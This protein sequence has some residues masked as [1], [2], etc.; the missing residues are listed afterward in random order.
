MNQ[1]GSTRSAWFTGV[2]DHNY[3]FRIRAR[4]VAGNQ[5]DYAATTSTHINACTPNDFEPDDDKDHARAIQVEAAAEIHKI[6]GAGDVDWFAFAPNP[7]TSYI[8]YTNQLG[9]TTDTA[10]TL[11]KVDGSTIL[12]ENGSAGGAQYAVVIARP[13]GDPTLY[14]RIRHTDPLVAGDAVTYNLS[15]LPVRAV[16]HLPNVRR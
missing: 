15:I 10:L 4:D 9:P 2:L 6:C 14:V 1:T 12:A 13:T 5:S 16:L 11:F 7:A 3:A 8:I